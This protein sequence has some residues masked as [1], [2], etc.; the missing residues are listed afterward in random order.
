MPFAA[1]FGVLSM[2]AGRVVER[3]GAR[4]AISAGLAAC[5]L[6]MVLLAVFAGDAV[7]LTVLATVVA[8]AGMSLLIA[9][10][11]TV[12]MNDLPPEQAGDG[13][14]FSMVSRF[15]GAAVGVAIVGS[16]FAAAYDANLPGASRGAPDERGSRPGC[17]RRVRRRGRRGLR[18]DRGDRRA[19]RGGRVVRAG[20]GAGVGPAVARVR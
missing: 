17:P 13:S 19:G 9:P 8:G 10:A 3:V 16:V 15:V 1:V 2:W 11:S 6:G 12:L 4:L 14:S 7:A 18:R 20:P 5:A